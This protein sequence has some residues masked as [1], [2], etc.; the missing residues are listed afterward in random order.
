MNTVKDGRTD[1][2]EA[3]ILVSG[4]R[5]SECE[6]LDKAL[7]FTFLIYRLRMVIELDV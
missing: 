6:T 2:Q 4:L 5:L 3:F 7:S 1:L